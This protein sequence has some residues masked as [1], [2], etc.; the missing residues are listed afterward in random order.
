MIVNT[1]KTRGGKHDV[2]NTCSNVLSDNSTPFT[3]VLSP[4]ASSRSLPT[5][6]VASVRY[7][8]RNLSPTIRPNVSFAEIDY[9]NPS[10]Q[11]S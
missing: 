1:W 9:K 6:T 11:V 10:F 4:I 3:I 7:R 5:T 2:A 8:S